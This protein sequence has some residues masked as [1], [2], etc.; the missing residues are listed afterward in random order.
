MT[1]LERRAVNPLTDDPGF[2]VYLHWPYCAAICPYCA[3]NV[4]RERGRDDE[5]RALLEAL[6][7]DLEGWRARTGARALASLYLGGGT[8][9]RLAPDEVAALV[10]RARTLW[11]ADAELEV[12][13]EAN[14]DDCDL[15]RL[16]GFAD[17]GVTRLSIGVQALDDAALKALGRW[18]SAADAR[19]AVGCARGVFERVSLDLIHARAGQTVDG[20][21]KELADA[22]A[23][24]VEHVSLYELTIEP[25]TAFARRAA[26]GELAAADDARGAAF[27]DVNAEVCAAAGFEAYETSNWA[28]G[29]KARSAHNLI[30]WRSGEWAG[31]GP[32]A[33]GRLGPLGGERIATETDKGIEAYVARV[34]ETGW[35]AAEEE[36][37]GAEAQLEEALLMGLRLAEGVPLGRLA[38]LV[39]GPSEDRLAA[40]EAD[41][42]LTRRDGRLI[43]T[44]K[45]RLLVDRIVLELLSSL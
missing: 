30:Y 29:P 2:G 17:A 39:G 21:A 42:L 1:K 7:A 41:G 38:D 36:R 25:G 3:F 9:S 26:R 18:H 45:G 12:T 8:P 13:L 22:L 6:H 23:L 20:W 11:R 34:R 35:G 40:L 31:V 5:R 33:H 19:A 28:R 16:R 32:G 44:A 37:L 15:A 43:A 10:A 27:L 24:G 14:P 4:V